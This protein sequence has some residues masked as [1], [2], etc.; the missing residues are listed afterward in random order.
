MRLPRFFDAKA[1]ALLAAVIALTAAKFTPCGISDRCLAQG[2]RTSSSVDTTELFR[3]QAIREEIKG[4]ID[5]D[6]LYRF[7]ESQ[8]A[9]FVQEHATAFATLDPNDI[10]AL[11]KL[12]TDRIER[13]YG[14]YLDKKVQQHEPEDEE[15]RASLR[16]WIREAPENKRFWKM[17]RDGSRQFLEKHRV[18]VRR[19][20]QRVRQNLALRQL[21]GLYRAIQHSGDRELPEGFFPSARQ[22]SVAYETPNER[23]QLGLA[24]YRRLRAEVKQVLG[25]QPLFT[26]TEK[27]LKALADRVTAVGY[28]QLG[29]QYGTL[30]EPP[31][32]VTP[33][34]IR[35]EFAARLD[36]YAANKNRE[37]HQDPVLPRK[38]Y[39]VFPAAMHEAIERANSY[40]DERIGDE[41]KRRKD[42][43]PPVHEQ[44]RNEVTDAIRSAPFP[45]HDAVKSKDDLKATFKERLAELVHESVGSATKEAMEA[46]IA[47]GDRN[48]HYDEATK[49]LD[50]KAISGVPLLVGDRLRGDMP[51]SLKGPWTRHWEEVL[52]DF[53]QMIWEVRKALAEEELRVYS[54]VLFSRSWKPSDDE[55][56]KAPGDFSVAWLQK[57][58][59]LW[60]KPTPLEGQLLE[61]TW[62]LLRDRVE[63]AY[64]RAEA[65][66]SRQ[67]QLVEEAKPQ[68]T[69]QMLIRSSEDLQVWL[70]AYARDVR[71]R[72]L[73]DSSPPDGLRASYPELLDPVRQ[74]IAGVAVEILMEVRQQRI[75]D[76]LV[77]TLGG[78]L[79]EKPPREIDARMVFTDLRNKV[80]DEW[81]KDDLA[82]KARRNL[83]PATIRHLEEEI[84]KILQ[85]GAAVDVTSLALLRQI[86][87]ADAYLDTDDCRTLLRGKIQSTPPKTQRELAPYLE[88]YQNWVLDQWTNDPL[89]DELQINYLLD[90]TRDQIKGNLLK[91]LDELNIEIAITGPGDYQGRDGGGES[92]AGDSPG[93][94]A[95]PGAGAGGGPGGGDGGGA[96]GGPGGGPGGGAGQFKLG[97]NA[98]T[99][100]TAGLLMLIAILVA[101][102][103]WY[104]KHLRTIDEVLALVRQLGSTNRQI[105]LLTALVKVDCQYRERTEEELYGLCE[106]ASQASSPSLGSAATLTI[107]RS[108]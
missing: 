2:P 75:V 85:Q 107:Q 82:T 13:R 78:Q 8:L 95:G 47:A 61:E 67:A 58:K 19:D 35:Q 97:L 88:Q 64:R 9:D 84:R 29:D 10:A 40:L 106:T 43:R 57:R 98:Y 56:G 17:I 76:K 45:H 54:N 73:S 79:A 7:D 74:Q 33:P 42:H 77:Q 80:E 15:A 41:L 30:S 81:R 90:D 55:I 87:L 5:S 21:E 101:L 50:L 100:I 36:Q 51:E 46:S 3:R 93:K 71:R 44:L 70:D 63:E 26:E 38:A 34:V 65:A 68:M 6:Q 92:A 99:A 37:P 103:Y 60:S 83:R 72:W 23:K 25:E 24:T 28:G 14:E 49:R 20:Y 52:H 105:A 86:N 62:S 89:S 32:A 96:G 104:R 31:T 18:A 91:I 94:S 27:E 59:E 48:P 53:E 1:R 39:P 69:S 22:V 12:L 11:E 16:K 102:V 108:P 4:A 66:L